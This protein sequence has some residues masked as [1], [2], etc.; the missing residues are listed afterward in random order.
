MFSFSP[1]PLVAPAAKT[2][3]SAWLPLGS[4]FATRLLDIT[5]RIVDR[6]YALDIHRFSLSRRARPCSIHYYYY[7]PR[8]LG[9]FIK[10]TGAPRETFPA[11]QRGPRHVEGRFTAGYS[12][13]LIICHC[14]K[15]EHGACLSSQ[16]INK[17]KKEDPTTWVACRHGFLPSTLETAACDDAHVTPLPGTLGSLNTSHTILKRTLF[18]QRRACVPSQQQQR[19]RPSPTDMFRPKHLNKL[20]HVAFNSPSHE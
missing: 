16:Q 7:S 17:N 18:S 3:S 6:E 1:S 4:S 5:R 13:I 11:R 8:A 9:L 19:S 2:C 20:G 12:A 14:T 10:T 15:T